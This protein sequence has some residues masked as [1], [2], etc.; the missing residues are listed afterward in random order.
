MTKY[1]DRPMDFADAT[2]IVLGESLA[3]TSVFTLDRRDFGVY[4]IG[5]S[6]PTLLPRG[7]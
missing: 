2:L 7:R 1:E 6:K 3:T 4:R 5:R